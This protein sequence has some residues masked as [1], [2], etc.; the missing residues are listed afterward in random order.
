MIA[1]QSPVWLWLV[2]RSVRR[3]PP[4]PLSSR[5]EEGLRG[6]VRCLLGAD[7]PADPYLDFFAWR[8]AR[9]PGVRT[10]CERLG[11]GADAAAR[12]EAAGSLAALDPAAR[13]RVF[14]RLFP[15]APSPL[16]VRQPFEE[17]RQEI[18]RRFS[19]T[20]AWVALGY[21]TWPGTPRGLEEYLLPPSGPRGG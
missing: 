9:I 11:A 8:S 19:R 20:D 13:D 17:V 12:L 18:L 4:G 14:R 16:R 15:E 7:V 3:L 5:A 2:S 6:A 10:A 1:S 21:R